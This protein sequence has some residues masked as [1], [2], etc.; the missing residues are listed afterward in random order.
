MA[1]RGGSGPTIHNYYYA[2]PSMSAAAPS[3]GI[4]RRDLV[5]QIAADSPALGFLFSDTTRGFP[6]VL[7]TL[8]SSL[9]RGVIPDAESCLTAI[10]RQVQS[11]KIDMEGEDGA[12]VKLRSAL[13]KKNPRFGAI[14]AHLNSVL[15][16]RDPSDID[17]SKLRVLLELY[18]DLARY[19]AAQREMAFFILDRLREYNRVP[20]HN[21]MDFN[22][23]I[24]MSLI[25][26][27]DPDPR[28]DLKETLLTMLG[29][30]TLSNSTMDPSPIFGSLPIEGSRGKRRPALLSNVMQVES[31]RGAAVSR[32][33]SRLDREDDVDGDDLS[34]V[35]GATGATHKGAGLSGLEAH[36]TG[37]AVSGFPRGEEEIDNFDLTD[38][39]IRKAIA[40]AMQ[41][42]LRADV[43]Q[44]AKSSPHAPAVLR[45]LIT[46]WET[47]QAHHHKEFESYKS[48]LQRTIRRYIINNALESGSDDDQFSVRKD[49]QGFFP[50]PEPSG[51]VEEMVEEEERE[52]TPIPAALMTI[53]LR[54]DEASSKT[55]GLLAK[56]RQSAA[57]GTSID[58]KD[59]MEEQR[60]GPIIK[61][62]HEARKT[63]LLP[64]QI[65]SDEEP[66]TKMLKVVQTLDDR[67]KGEL[68]SEADTGPLDLTQLIEVM[69]TTETGNCE[70]LCQEELRKIIIEEII[71]PPEEA[72]QANQELR[73]QYKTQILNLLNFYQSFYTDHRTMS[74]ESRVTIFTNDE[75]PAVPARGHPVRPAAGGHRRVIGDV[76]DPGLGA[77]L[78][79]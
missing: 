76:G 13:T 22:G 47:C 70:D 31:S 37:A 1:A 38:P 36:A 60:M 72:T 34:A 19:P 54:L 5:A 68:A 62:Q 66:K 24:M 35:S 65:W 14:E 39:D 59:E 12:T 27:A 23:W 32:P 15:A 58:L 40:Q 18:R 63:A 45:S 77:A 28:S 55:S 29:N 49:M 46:D 17:P 9:L 79:V 71:P 16:V 26:D 7:S 74:A 57:E 69:T 33:V 11:E 78:D 56:I 44:K 51:A 52:A 73:E 67:F 4:L 10:L 21:N 6:P 3:T 53:L 42:Q 2:P 30:N 64:I 75:L 8:K 50:S 20:R 25:T 41:K 61:E 43:Y 48:L